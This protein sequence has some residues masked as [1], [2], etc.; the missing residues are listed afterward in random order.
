MQDARPR[1]P[2]TAGTPQRG[3]TFCQEAVVTKK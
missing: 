2:A 3:Q 1:R